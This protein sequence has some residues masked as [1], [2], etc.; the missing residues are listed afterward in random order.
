MNRNLTSIPT[1][2]P[3]HQW[4]RI[5]HLAYVPGTEDSVL[6]NFME[7][8][9]NAFRL[10][11]HQV[12]DTPNAETDVLLTTAKFGE[13]LNWRKALLFTA[14]SKYHL[15]R[16]PIIF[17]IL[18]STPD[19]F[20]SLLAH[21]QNALEKDPPN[22]EDF[23]FD[24]LAENAYLT[25]YEQG[26]RGG[27]ILSLLR[28]L[29][30]QAKCIRII[31]V[32][33]DEQPIEAYTF[34]LVGAYPRSDAQN[35][36]AFYEDLMLRIVTAASTHEITAHQVVGE[37]IPYELWQ[38]LSTPEAMRQAGFELGKR[39][40]FT[41]MVRI[42]NLVSVPAVADSVASQYSEGCFATW[43]PKLNAL[44]ATITGSARPV[45][46]DNLTENELAVIVGVRADGQGALV[47]HVQGKRNDPP[48]S[49]AVEMLLMDKDL[50]NIEIR[51]EDQTTC[52]VPV[53]RS[54]LHGHRGLRA[55][56]PTLVEFVTLDEP[57]YY[58][59][60]SCSTE[61]QA[62]A[63]YRAFSR[64]EALRNPQDPRLVVFTVLP[65]HGIVLAEKWVEGKAPFQVMWELMDQGALQIDNHV[66]Q[67]PFNFVPTQ[68]GL[69]II[70]LA[71]H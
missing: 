71:A 20:H 39:H 17:T 54:K 68:N 22:P 49:E 26:K 25:L 37:E 40:F 50:P 24:G 52:K 59:P 46:K 34:D 28:L 12:V 66:P 9:L 61:A 69:M 1:F 44:I 4:L 15:P 38:T 57:F 31:L 23:N 16:S 45:D 14:R 6:N 11:G 3:S 43:E 48:S 36:A 18:H 7:G 42:A 58:Y 47:R 53:A 41:D 35:P 2:N 65:G 33:G 19:Q 13:A 32:I 63:I 30:S 21:F 62:Q 5:L 51:R 64:S 60:V 56:D 67:G 70:N 29:Q 27:P 10:H 8:L 55:Y